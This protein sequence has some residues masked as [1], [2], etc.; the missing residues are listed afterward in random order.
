MGWK[1]SFRDSL[2]KTL[3]EEGEK[4]N[5]L[6]VLTADI[7]KSV[8][9][10]DFEKKFPERYINN[11][12]SEADMIS[13][14]AGL[15]TT[16]LIPVVVDFAMFAVLKPY[17]QIRNSISYPCLNV[18]IIATHGGIAIGSRDGATHQTVEDI[19][20]MRALPNMTVIT[21]CDGVE[22]NAAIK[23]AINHDGPVYLRLGFSD[24]T[25]VI[26]EEGKKFDIGK[27]D[28]LKNGNDVTLIACGVMVPL[29]L[30]AAESLAINGIAARVINMYSI[31]PL[32]EDAVIK[33]AKETGAIVTIE[34]HNVIGGMGS[35]V[36]EVLAKHS[37]SPI[38][39]VALQDTFGESGTQQ[40]LMEKYGLTVDAIISAAKCSIGRKGNG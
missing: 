29:A 7:G 6:V 14:A 9:I 25:T 27:S 13:H 16:G 30:Q 39:M 22:T 28:E 26:Y 15:A 20:I 40:E 38:E 34:D 21:A 12:V 33:A 5:G 4:N 36:C 18:K 23:A 31:K 32:D 37:P 2:G 24:N 35:A 19:A 8:R 17:E 10:L 11:G 1:S 3:L